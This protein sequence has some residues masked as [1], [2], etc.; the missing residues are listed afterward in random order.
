MIR[1][2]LVVAQHGRLVYAHEF[3]PHESLKWSI[4]GVGSLVSALHSIIP[5]LS[6]GN[7]IR[8]VKLDDD[9]LLIQ[10][11]DKLVFA[12]SADERCTEEHEKKLKFIV[13]NFTSQ[14]EDLIPFIDENSD[15]E[16][17]NDFTDVLNQSNLFP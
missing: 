5:L 10:S 4:K 14:Y 9:Y 3:D 1:N 15:L 7:S 6:G 12:L 16:V 8:K 11:S 13:D 2:I 17:F